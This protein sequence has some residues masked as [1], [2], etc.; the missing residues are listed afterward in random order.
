MIILCQSFENLGDAS[1]RISFLEYALVMMS[2]TEFELCQVGLP[3]RKHSAD[4]FLNNMFI[5]LSFLLV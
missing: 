1:A 5:F 2:K 4:F 3:E